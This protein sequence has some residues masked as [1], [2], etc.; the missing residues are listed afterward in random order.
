VINQAIC[1]IAEKNVPEF[2]ASTGRFEVDLG[3]QDTYAD[4]VI[5]FGD[6]ELHMEFHHLSDAHCKA[7]S[8]AA[9][10]MKKLRVYSNHYNI[11]PR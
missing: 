7:A 4:A 5:P 11:T 3:E 9:Y 6:R 8:I 10:I 1:A 2:S